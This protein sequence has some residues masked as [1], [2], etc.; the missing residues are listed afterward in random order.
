MKNCLTRLAAT[1]VLF[2]CVS[3]LPVAASP[4]THLEAAIDELLQHHP[5]ELLGLHWHAMQ[6]NQQDH[7]IASVYHENGLQPVWVTSGGPGERAE[8]IYRVLANAVH[9]GLVAEDYNVTDIGSLWDS[10]EP[11]N[12]ARLD[13]LLTAGLVDYVSDLRHG[14]VQPKNAEQA[15]F[16]HAADRDINAPAIVAEAMKSSDLESYLAAQLPSHERYRNTRGGLARYRQIAANGGWPTVNPGETIHPGEQDERLATIRQRLLAT[17]DLQQPATRDMSY[18]PATVTAVKLFQQRHGLDDDGVIGQAT[19]S[20][21]NVPVEQRIRQLEINL[22]R[23]RWLTRDLGERHVLVD[24][25][26]FEAATFDSGEELYNMRVI[27]GKH[28]HETPVF[29]DTIKYVVINPYWTITPSIARH[30][31]LPK[32]R[33]DPSYLAKK[34]ISLF[35]GWSDNKEIDPRTIDWNKVTPKQMN[36][37]RLRQNPGPGN[38]LGTLKIV[39]PN[40][41]SVYLHDTPNHNLFER[42]ERAFSHGCIRMSEPVRQAA[43]VLGDAG[44][45]WSEERIADIVKTGQR[46]VVRLE[47]P[48]QVHLTY[49]TALADADHRVRFVPD[50]Y[51]RDARLERALY[52]D[53]ALL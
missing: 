25:P 34:N 49:Q 9:E 14:R 40:K 12:L 42:T 50:F 53:D 31:M 11:F 44:A 30:E 32:L 15:V 43:L 4:Q 39:F 47:Q 36:Q 8:V 1:V 37:Y 48:V 3:A 26:A 33:R 22:E 41:Y 46:T 2:G 35:R 10:R 6:P 28:H 45:G 51:Q 23:W 7:I 27:V 29:S 52:G 38:A 18:D 24:I 20:A 16:Y 21:M 5:S 17:G 13:V 19:I